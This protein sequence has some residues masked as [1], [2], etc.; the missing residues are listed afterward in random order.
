MYLLVNVLEYSRRFK[1]PEGDRKI[2]SLKTD[3]ELFQLY[4]FSINPVLKGFLQ[5]LFRIGV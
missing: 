5:R 3:A 4:R 2:L 1:G